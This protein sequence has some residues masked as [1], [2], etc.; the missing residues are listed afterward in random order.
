LTTNDI[1]LCFYPKKTRIDTFSEKTENSRKALSPS[2]STSV[3]LEANDGFPNMPSPFRRPWISRRPVDPK[4][5][6]QP[7]TD[8]D[9]TI[10]HGNDLERRKASKNV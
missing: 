7:A 5:M 1:V 2:R 6:I 4:R 3:S 8:A 9:F 10:R